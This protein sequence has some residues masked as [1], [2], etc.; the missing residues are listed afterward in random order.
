MAAFQD[1]LLLS[2]GYQTL[3]A[4]FGV[5]FLIVVGL[6]VIIIKCYRKVL[7][8]QALIR[9]GM[10]GTKVCFS[11]MIVIWPSASPM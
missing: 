5:G 10:G 7:Q 6:L 9:N 2:P 1:M 11:G 4:V 8:G 3:V